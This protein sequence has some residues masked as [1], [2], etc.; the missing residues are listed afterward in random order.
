VPQVRVN[1]GGWCR[2]ASDFELKGAT[3]DGATLPG[4]VA[5]NA[6]NGED[7]Q[8][9]YPHPIYGTLGTGETY[10]FHTGGANVAF[11]D[12]SVRLIRATIPIR[13]FARLATRAGGEV[14]ADLD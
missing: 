10:S 9:Q 11:G 7:V 3:A 5:I 12:G 14:T 8:N 6:T 1:G 13:T 4:P 2:P